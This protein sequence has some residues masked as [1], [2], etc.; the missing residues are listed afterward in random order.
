MTFKKLQEAVEYFMN[1]SLKPEIKKAES[2]VRQPFEHAFV[3]CKICPICDKPGDDHMRE[4]GKNNDLKI[5]C[6]EEES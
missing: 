3:P 5:I 4:L 6:P 1:R 2:R